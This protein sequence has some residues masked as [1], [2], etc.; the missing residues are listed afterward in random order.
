M[1]LKSCPKCNSTN[2]KP[3]KGAIMGFHDHWIS[4]QNC[5]YEGRHAR[6]AYEAAELWNTHTEK[7]DGL[8]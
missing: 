3:D 1:E 6:T 5:G 7:S 8:V 4:C 2:V